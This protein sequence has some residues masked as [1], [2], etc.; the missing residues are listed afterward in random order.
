MR[1]IVRR[2]PKYVEALQVLSANYMRRGDHVEGL[3][4]DRKLV[5]LAPQ[6]PTILYNL[7]CSLC[8]NQRRK[9]AL[10][11]L[12]KAIDCGFDDYHLLMRDPD[13]DDLRRESHFDQIRERILLMDH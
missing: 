10:V 5:R 9:Q 11:A 13:L 4:V 7:A 8:L 6:D 12:N 3:K 2:D 1:K